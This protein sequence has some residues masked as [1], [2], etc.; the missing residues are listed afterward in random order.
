VGNYIGNNRKKER[1][2]AEWPTTG[3][4]N[5]IATGRSGIYKLSFQIL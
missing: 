2:K 5:C 1:K 3:K 4:Y